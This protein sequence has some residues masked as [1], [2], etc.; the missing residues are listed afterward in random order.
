MENYKVQKFIYGL[1]LG[2]FFVFLLLKLT[3]NK[4]PAPIEIKPCKC[5]TVRQTLDIIAKYEM[6]L[7]SLNIAKRKETKLRLQDSVEKYKNILI[8]SDNLI[9][10]K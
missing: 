7:D 8:E 10:K 2:L 4:E 3:D 1:A 9:E 6:S 5:L